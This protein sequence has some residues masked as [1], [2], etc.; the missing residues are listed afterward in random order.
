MHQ[1][2]AI[3]CLTWCADEMRLPGRT[4]GEKI[5]VDLLPNAY[6]APWLL[7]LISRDVME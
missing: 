2:R 4:F 1:P 7:M 5:E 3:P 6:V